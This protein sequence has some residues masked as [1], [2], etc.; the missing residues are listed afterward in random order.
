MWHNFWDL[1]CFEVEVKRVNHRCP[2][3]SHVD[4]V[5]DVESDDLS[6]LWFI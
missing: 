3:V 1:V 4:G 5:N 2:S 6:E